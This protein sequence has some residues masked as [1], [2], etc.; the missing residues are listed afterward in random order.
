MNRHIQS[1][2]TISNLA[3]Q[4]RGTLEGEVLP[5]EAPQLPSGDFIRKVIHV[6]YDEGMRTGKRHVCALALNAALEQR[7]LRAQLQ[8]ASHTNSKDFNNA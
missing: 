6:L 7:A 2:T 5:P 4:P 1:N 8:G 3:D